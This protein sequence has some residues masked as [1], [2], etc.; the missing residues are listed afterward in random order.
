MGLCKVVNVDKEKCTNCHACIA[1]CPIKYCFEVDEKG[2]QVNKDL[3]IGCGRCYFACKHKA[4]SVIDDF[5]EFLESINRGEKTCLIVSP[6][7]ISSFPNQYLQMLSWLKETF[8]FTGI[9]HEG[10]GAEIA[11]IMN[12]DYMKKTGLTPIIS[13]HCPS[14]TEFIKIYVP[15]LL[16]YLSPYHS[17]AVILAKYIRQILNFDGNI[18]YLGP[19]LSKRREFRDPD[20]DNSI[21]FNLTFTNL[22]K[23]MEVHKVDLT[24]YTKGNF[25]WIKPERGVVFSQPGGFKD[26]VEGYYDSP[27]IQH[28]EGDII[29]KKYLNDLRKLVNKENAIMPIMIDL[30]GC[31]GGCFRGPAALNDLTLTETQA[32]INSV[33]DKAKRY[34]ITKE[35]AHKTFRK[36]I[37]DNS[38]VDLHRVYYSESATPVETLTNDELKEEYKALNK[39]KPEDFL[40]CTS[41]GYASCQKFATALHYNLNVKKNCRHYLETSLR[42]AMADSSELSEGISITTNE[43]RATMDEISALA[44]NAKKAFEKISELANTSK[45]LNNSM[46]DQSDSFGPIVNAI[47]EVSE[48]INLL[49]LN[50]A[51]EASRAGE[52]GKG[53]AVVSTEIRKLADKTKSE[54]DKIVPIMQQIS[55]NIKTTDENSE[56]LKS[57]TNTF[58]ASIDTIHRTITEVTASIGELATA[59]EKLSSFSKKGVL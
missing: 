44:D 33:S 6:A 8:V 58:A 57:E 55:A 49:S 16:D 11:T 4:I 52:M 48:Q 5:N 10:L 9:F 34:Y 32:V 38:D 41:C 7:I 14:I 29:Y 17:P 15:E 31:I 28:I 23:Y 19:C 2:V 18:A 24:Q 43:M 46:R 26:I 22:K 3:C 30:L 36:F 50:A 12:L 13:Q 47:S 59:A 51:I 40:N 1:A 21:Q 42:N 56:N 39:H 37:D 27:N 35:K 53:F 45:A 54:T 25:E 20:T